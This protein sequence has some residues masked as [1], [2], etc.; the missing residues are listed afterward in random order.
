MIDLR[1][2]LVTPSTLRGFYSL[3][4]SGYVHEEYVRRMVP[5]VLPAEPAKSRP[6]TLVPAN[7]VGRLVNTDVESRSAPQAK[8]R[9]KLQLRDYQRDAVELLEVVNCGALLCD[10]VGLGKSVEVLEFLAGHPE[11]RPF[12][13]SGPLLASSA[14]VGKHADPKKY[15]GLEVCFLRG[16]SP[17][18]VPEDAD[19]Y[20][21]NYEILSEW[22]E[23]LKLIEPRFL[24]L[25]EAHLLRNNTS[26]GVAARKLT[27]SQSIVKRAVLTATPVVNR[28]SDLYALL[29][30][31]QP[32]Q[33]GWRSQW[34]VRY[35]G[36]VP[37]EYSAYVEKG[38]TNVDEL[39]ARMQTMSLRRSR[40]EVR[41]ELPPFSRRQI[42][43]PE[44]ALEPAPMRRY[45]KAESDIVGLILGRHGSFQG[46]ALQQATEMASA[47]S[48][49][50]VPAAINTALELL[51]SGPLVVFTW[52]K[53]TAAAIARA[54]KHDAEIFG[55]VTSTL[56][57]AKRDTAARGFFESKADRRVFIATVGTAGMAMNELRVADRALFVDLYWVPATL[58][59]AEGRI[60][61]GNK[62]S[63]CEAIYLTVEKSVDAIMF[64]KL[65]RKAEAI[66]AVV[67]DGAA[68]SLCEALGGKRPGNDDL[69]EFLAALAKVDVEALEL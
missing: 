21:L 47:L 36:A 38:E 17:A 2:A 40:F 58:I 41:K 67:G 43:I 5:G 33:W 39:Q 45:R 3:I 19:G 54:L 57:K 48:A 60:H 61:R 28:I 35:A 9:S 55:P 66:S 7:L 18:D 59:Q 62:T 8:A 10:D 6:N 34:I 31:A 32:R 20:F 37:G 1:G 51:L 13:I 15:Y 56:A 52:Y 50:K 64:S 30:L 12:V 29:D 49:A 23:W 24:V 69:K 25:D 53:E 26:A 22:S 42:S 14:W 11:L 44:D 46:I 27:R 4:A 63:P 65:Q 68:L 16:R